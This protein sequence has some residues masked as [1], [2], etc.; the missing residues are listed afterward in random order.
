MKKKKSLRPFPDRL[1]ILM[2]VSLRKGGYAYGVYHSGYTFWFYDFITDKPTNNL[3]LFKSSRWFQEISCQDDG[4]SASTFDVGEIELTP[5]ERQPVKTWSRV[6]D[7]ALRA[8][9][10]TPCKLYDPTIP[11]L[12]QRFYHITE[13]ELPKYQEYMQLTHT[14]LL[15]Y[16]ETQRPRM[17]WIEVPAHQVFTPPVMTESETFEPLT[18]F[19]IWLSGLEKMEVKDL[20]GIADEIDAELHDKGA[21]DVIGT[22]AMSE[23]DQHNI[24]VQNA[25]GKKPEALACIRRVLLRLKADPADTEIMEQEP[26]VKGDDITHSLVV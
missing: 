24:A 21:G 26:D 13:A 15:K 22:G 17:K 5:E 2:C 11:D 9:A 14:Q 25:P 19:E 18:I 4:L 7:G 12:S 8:G 3:E 16:L 10:P 1:G 20:Q 6:T 23:G